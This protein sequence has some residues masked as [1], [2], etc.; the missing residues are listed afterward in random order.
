MVFLYI[1]SANDDF[2]KKN[3]R[4]ATSDIL[5]LMLYVLYLLL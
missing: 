4:Y 5:F 2:F 1:L 3:V